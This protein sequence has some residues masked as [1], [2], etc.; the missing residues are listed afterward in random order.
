M[1]HVECPYC[2]K[3][4]RLID[5]KEIYGKSYGMAYICHPCDAY[6]GTHMN[7]NKPLGRLANR[8]LRLWRRKAHDSFDPLWKTGRFKGRRKSAYK[9]LSRKMKIPEEKTH[10]AMFD[11]DQCKQ[12]IATVSEERKKSSAKK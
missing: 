6:V 8:E 10:I 12:V 1:I 9:W 2:G 4:A 5:S 7:T 3:S 11:V